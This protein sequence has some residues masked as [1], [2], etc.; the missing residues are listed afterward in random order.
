MIEKRHGSSTTAGLGL[1]Q[2]T[3]TGDPWRGQAKYSK[4]ITATISIVIL[5]FTFATLWS[6]WQQH[7]RSKCADTSRDMAQSP[8]SSSG[9]L[10]RF[11]AAVRMLAYRRLPAY[12]IGFI[13]FRLPVLGATLALSAFMLGFTLWTFIVQPYYRV[14]RSFGSPPL[15]LRSGMMALGLM[16]FIYVLGSKVNFVSLLIGVSHGKLQVYHQW[17]ARFMLFLATVHA[18]PFIHQPLADDGVAGLREAFF[19]D[20]INTT[21]VIAYACLF[22]LSFA[23]MTGIRERCYELFLLVHVPVAIIFLGYMFVHCQALLT[24]WRYL[25]ATAAMYM[26]SVFLRF[27]SQLRQN[28][29]LALGKCRIEALPSNLTR[30]TIESAIRWKPGHHVFVRFPSLSPLSAHPFTIVSMPSPDSH[31]LMSTVVLMARARN[32]LTKRLYE[33]AANTQLVHQGMNERELTL[34]AILDGP[35]GQDASI[36]SFQHVL[37]LAGGSGITFVLAALL[38]LSWLWQQKK[39]AT[40]SVHLIWSIRDAESIDWVREHLLAIYALAPSGALRISIHVSGKNV[41]VGDLGLPTSWQVQYGSHPDAASEVREM[42]REASSSSQE[43]TD[44]E[45]TPS[46]QSDAAVEQVNRSRSAVIVVCGPSGM[47]MDAS[48]AVAGIQA[49]IVRKK[50]SDLDVSLIAESFGF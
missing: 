38:E 20:S 47:V 33:R 9:R 43:E 31:Q 27:A 34:S 44:I 8:R 36:A 22:V 23:S 4:G 15:A 13:N 42:A 45:K 35:Y 11:T 2:T 16:P 17:L 46:S 21:G 29:L 28:N 49:D 6:R 5:V 1:L 50:L 7:W 19:S 41:V 39:A 12:R 18:I 32:G 3:R 14:D 37:L 24:S 30:M 26:L 48:N 10:S 40:Q 25:W